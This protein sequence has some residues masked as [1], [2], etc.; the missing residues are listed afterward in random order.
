MARITLRGNP[1]DTF[2]DLPPIGAAAPEFTLAGPDLADRTLAECLGST[3]VLNIFPSL[4]TPV[5]AMS[6]RRFNADAGSLPGVR[7]L[8]ISA[9]LPFAH[10]RFCELEGLKNVTGLSVFRSPGFGRDYGVL[11]TSGPLRGLLSRAVVIVDPSGRV[12]YTEQVPE[13]GEEPDYAAAL[14][15]LELASS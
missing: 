14:A 4:D 10:G 2:S 12:A 11:I 5:C 8:C 15:S 13:I 7:V 6:V 1:L 3:V 9:D